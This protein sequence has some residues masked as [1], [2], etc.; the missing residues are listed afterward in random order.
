ME[1][2]IDA[3][4]DKDRTS[5]AT[6]HPLFIAASSRHTGNVKLLLSRGAAEQKQRPLV[7]KV[8]WVR[9]QLT[10][11]KMAKGDGDGLGEDGS[12][13]LQLLHIKAQRQNLLGSLMCSVSGGAGGGGGSSPFFMSCGIDVSFVG[14]SGS[15]SEENDADETGGMSE[16]GAGDGLRREFLH[17]VVQVVVV[18]LLCCV[19]RNCNIAMQC[20][21]VPCYAVLYCIA[22]LYYAW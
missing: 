8:E 9:T 1:L 11:M 7:E 19:V 17:L 6:L 4:A 5:S 2:L 15:G 20:H 13:G 22:I 10:S 16:S 18:P 12:E 3:G 14:G 21:A